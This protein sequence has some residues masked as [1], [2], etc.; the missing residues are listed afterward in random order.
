MKLGILKTGA[1]PLSLSDFGNYPAMFRKLLGP[2]A[3]D[4]EVFDAETGHLPGSIDACPAYIITGS[5]NGAYETL[6]WIADLKRF[7][8]QAKG[9]A[10]LVGICFGH[11]IMAEAFGGKVIKSPKGWGAGAHTYSVQHPQPW[12]DGA[13]RITLPASHQDQVVTLPPAAEIVAASSFTRYGMLAYNDQPAISMQL[14]PEFEPD[15]AAALVEIR[16]GHG[17]T[18]EQADCALTS[19]QQPLDSICAAGL[20][21]RFLHSAVATLGKL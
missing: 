2:S 8:H 11:Q 9:Q 18:D 1:P 13:S 3:Y 15:Y 12:L 21:R 20:I 4:Y 7:L 6:P 14:H 17:L 19:L 5:A 10:A 16:R